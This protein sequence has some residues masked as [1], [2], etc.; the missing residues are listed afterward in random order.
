MFLVSY[1]EAYA[2]KV[3]IAVL[4]FENN[5]HPQYEWLSTGITDTII[6]KLSKSNQ[7]HLIEREKIIEIIKNKSI[8]KIGESERVLIGA[9]YL[10]IGS[11]TALNDQ[12]KINLRVSTAKSGKINQKSAF[13]ITGKV[14]EILALEVK[15]V[16]SFLK[17]YSFEVNPRE[18]FYR[19]SKNIDSYRCF[20]LGKEAY[21]NNYFQK[22]IQFFIEAQQKNEGFYFSSSHSWEGKARIAMSNSVISKNKIIIQNNHIKKFEKDAAE[23]APA[24]YDLGLAYKASGDHLKAIDAFDE[25]LRWY[26]R[27]AKPFRWEDTKVWA[28]SHIIKTEESP[29]FYEHGKRERE[30]GNYGPASYSNHYRNWITKN[31][32]IYYIG[33]SSLICKSIGEGIEKWS[34]KLDFLQKIRRNTNP[35]FPN[36]LVKRKNKIFVS[37]LATILTIDTDSGDILKK[38]N[39]S[40]PL[41]SIG[42]FFVFEKENLFLSHYADNNNKSKGTMLAHHIDSGKL[43]WKKEIPFSHA[44]TY[45]NKNIYLAPNNS[46]EVHMVNLINGETQKLHTF[47]NKIYQIW[48][49]KD[50]VLIRTTNTPTNYDNDLYFRLNYDTKSVIQSEKKIFFSYFYN[51]LPNNIIGSS[52]PF[53]DKHS[54]YYKLLPADLFYPKNIVKYMDSSLQNSIETEFSI[55]WFKLNNNQLYGWTEDKRI[56]GYNS[57]SKDLLW[58]KYIDKSISAIDFSDHYVVSKNGR[59]TIQVY[60]TTASPDSKRYLN[61]FIE[62]AYS[63]SFLG[64][65]NEAIDTIRIGLLNSGGDINANLCM[66]K[67]NLKNGNLN[68][69]LVHYSKVMKFSAVTTKQYREAE[70]VLNNRIGLFKTLPYVDASGR[71]FFNDTFYFFHR[72]NNIH[73]I[74]SYNLKSNEL[75]LNYCENVKLM[76]LYKSFLYVFDYDGTCYKIDMNTQKRIK[77]FV[78][79]PYSEI[80]ITY[81]P[82]YENASKRIQFIDDKI[83]FV[84]QNS[85]DKSYYVVA[86]NLESGKTE[87]KYPFKDYISVSCLDNILILGKY[88]KKYSKECRVVL[89]NPNTGKE[90][91]SKIFP[92]FQSMQYTKGCFAAMIN[93]DLILSFT[94]YRSNSAKLWRYPKVPF[95]N[96]NPNTGEIRN[97]T[98]A[99]IY[100]SYVA[101]DNGFISI[102]QTSQWSWG[103]K[104]SSTF[105]FREQWRDQKSYEIRYAD[106]NKTHPKILSQLEPLK[107]LADEFDL[108]KH[109][110]ALNDIIN[111]RVSR[112]LFIDQ[113]KDKVINRCTPRND[114]DRFTPA[115][116]NAR[117]HTLAKLLK[118]ESKSEEEE[119]FCARQ[120]MCLWNGSEKNS[121]IRSYRFPSGSYA[122]NAVPCYDDSLKEDVTIGNYRGVLLAFQIKNDT[123]QYC[124]WKQMPKFHDSTAYIPYIKNIF[125]HKGTLIVQSKNGYFLYNTSRLLNYMENNIKSENGCFSVDTN[126]SNLINAIDNDPTTFTNLEQPSRNIIGIDYGLKE[127]KNTLHIT[128]IESA[129]YL[130]GTCIQSSNFSETDGFENIAII[131]KSLTDSKSNTVKFKTKGAARYWRIVTRRGDAIKIAELKF[132]FE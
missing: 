12:I 34:I 33:R 57:D 51:N 67:L 49:G 120:L 65:M 38:I 102:E 46:N 91:W 9:E 52:I 44:V 63:Y 59:R 123:L 116:Y 103:N 119:K 93:N 84:A 23:A 7:F 35:R 60:S 75:N 99:Q 29:Y 6:S 2:N 130:Q 81:F 48:P 56:R 117:P 1:I 132:S 77:L 115:G 26:D 27:S 118:K 66:A 4:P 129:E 21:K 128:P 19:E 45:N 39:T 111:N 40:V 62:K 76:R 121:F 109:V 3:I 16:E 101:L 112:K 28:G 92:I 22:A 125:H 73:S 20:N 54:R 100:N 89:L 108:S 124:N 80:G 36:F 106:L 98:F 105:M 88:K 14:S 58:S 82:V 107:H 79:K 104:I 131:Q 41:Q 24:F 15:L 86:R 50:H 97:K 32:Y 17:G 122:S 113:Y 5:S 69:A 110:K 96:L 95:Y 74:A 126:S 94:H 18:L 64:K 30:Q 78:D 37:G 10:I 127:D 71:V 68:S 85:I 11:F 87:W 55:P 61:T 72:E 8:N 25:Y 83:I 31:G 90:N 70:S 114:K 43:L 13:S 42:S 47:K 53:M